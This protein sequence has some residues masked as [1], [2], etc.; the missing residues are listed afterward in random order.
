MSEKMNI[1][2]N[3]VRKNRLGNICAVLAVALCI[4]LMIAFVYESAAMLWFLAIFN[5]IAGPA[6]FVG[7]LI[8][9]RKGVFAGEGGDEKPL[10]E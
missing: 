1:P 4:V 8:E 7:Y 6:C 9:V 10:D 3:Q 2:A 5:F